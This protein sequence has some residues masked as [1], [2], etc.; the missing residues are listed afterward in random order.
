M[1][2]KSKILK[3][4]LPIVILA[5]G[6]VGMAGMVLSKTPPEKEVRSQAGTL[7]ETTALKVIDHRV[8]IQATGTVQPAARVNIVPQVGGRVIRLAE[9]FKEGR[10]FSQGQLL[11]E[12]EVADYQLAVEKSRADIARTEYDLA[13][14]ESQARVAR[15]EWERVKLDD[16]TQPN[17]LVLYEPQLKNAQ[18]ALS[19]ARADLEQRLLDLKRTKVYAP[20]NCR[21]SSKSVDVG[22]FVT[23]GQTVATVAGTDA[24]EIVIPVPLHELQWISIPRSDR[25]VGSSA[26]VHLNVGREHTWQGHI[27]RSLGEVD[28]QSRMI[29]LVVKVDD[30]YGLK[31]GSNNPLDLAEGLFVGVTLEG[32]T[33]HRIMAIPVSSLRHEQTLWLMGED[34]TLNILSVQVLRR[35]KDIVLVQGAVPKGQQLVTTQISGAA[36]G[37]RL[38]L[39]LEVQ[40]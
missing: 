20:F 19:S 5:A 1:D 40:S 27:D 32:R 16:K 14:V 22:Q 30:P 7:V 8:E 29:R 33:L 24:A 2:V 18:A 34:C 3:Y 12:I 15:M 25:E 31:P 6:L 23:A 26:S 4:I 21:I 13:S 39:A 35:E 11:F 9:D 10:F 17:P 36:Q 37:M 38:R 28:A